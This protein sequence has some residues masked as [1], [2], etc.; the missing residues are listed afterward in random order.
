M[1]RN[2]QIT[3]KTSEPD[4]RVSLQLDGSGKS[5][6]KTPVAFFNHMLELTARHGLFD[7]TVQAAGDIAVDAHHTIE[8]IGICLGQAAQQ[9]LGSKEKIQRYGEATIPMDEA[10]VRV[11]IDISGRPFLVLSSPPLRGKTGDFDLDLV[12]EFFQA[13][14]NHAKI[15]MH[16]DVI[17]GKN[18]HHIVEAMFKAFGRAFDSA[19]RIDE[20]SPGVP[21]TKG[22]L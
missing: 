8:D 15:T 6:C 12:E 18:F 11:A 10:L 13:F 14:F 1:G 16:I 17:R 19:T 20:R 3:R 2:A 4:V 21:S 7:I 22:M 5:T 9:A